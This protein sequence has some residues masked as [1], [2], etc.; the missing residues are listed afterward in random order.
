MFLRIEINTYT[1]THTHTHTHNFP[2][3]Q[4]IEKNIDYI[5]YLKDKLILSKVLPALS[6]RP[7]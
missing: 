6:L 1:H 2:W 7:S 5:I 4:D 3:F